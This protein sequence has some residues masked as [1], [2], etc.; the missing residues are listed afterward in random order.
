[1]NMTKLIKIIEDKYVLN[2]KDDDHIFWGNSRYG[3]L[4]MIKINS[5]TLGFLFLRYYYVEYDGKYCTKFKIQIQTHDMDDDIK[6]F[7]N[8][9]FFEFKNY[10]IDGI[11]KSVEDNITRISYFYSSRISHISE[12]YIGDKILEISEDN[13]SRLDN[14][15]I[16][17]EETRNSLKNISFLMPNNIFV[18]LKSGVVDSNLFSYEYY[19]LNNDDR[20]YYI[21]NNKNSKTKI[22]SQ[23]PKIW[24]AAISNNLSNFK[25]HCLIST[26]GLNYA[27]LKYF[28]ISLIDFSSLKQ[29]N[30]GTYYRIYMNIDLFK[31]ALD[32]PSFSFAKIETNGGDNNRIY[33]ITL[34][35]KKGSVKIYNDD[36]KNII[37]DILKEKNIFTEA[38]QLYLT[39][40]NT[41]KVFKRKQIGGDK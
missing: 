18:N 31:E 22:L 14:Y 28:D 10:N 7:I 15:E 20:E 23:K 17:D 8:N 27:K 34:K 6:K 9:K 4:G 29:I 21:K 26:F 40:N 38:D 16:A 36:V 3:F 30:K 2:F 39:F 11:R 19:F 5:N 1:M 41:A 25:T 32:S 12:I 24:Y 13:N 33:S 35:F 37:I